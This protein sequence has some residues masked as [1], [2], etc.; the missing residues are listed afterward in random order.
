VTKF[1]QYQGLLTNISLDFN[2]VNLYH[3]DLFV[4]VKYGWSVTY[5]DQRQR[6]ITLNM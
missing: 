1:D 6:L 3:G 5:F 2:N 4:V